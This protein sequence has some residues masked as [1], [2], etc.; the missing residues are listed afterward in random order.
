MVRRLKIDTACIN[1]LASKSQR[2]T[3]A[4]T[5]SV[6]KDFTPMAQLCS[7]SRI[8]TR[9]SARPDC[10]TSVVTSRSTLQ[11]D[12]NTQAQYNASIQNSESAAVR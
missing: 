8:R 6:V 7:L 10:E 12:A 3:G 1:D 5:L 2:A 4:L 9:R 11:L